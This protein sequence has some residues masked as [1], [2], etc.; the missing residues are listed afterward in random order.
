MAGEII[1][2]TLYRNNC[3]CNGGIPAK[4]GF[5]LYGVS[6]ERGDKTRNKYLN[7]WTLLDIAIWYQINALTSFF[8]LLVD[9]DYSSRVIAIHVLHMNCRVFGLCN[10]SVENFDITLVHMKKF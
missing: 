4:G 10:N 2:T 6:L 3:A 7:L 9:G 5:N 1:Y 8:F